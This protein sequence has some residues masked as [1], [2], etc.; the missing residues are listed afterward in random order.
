MGFDSEEGGTDGG[1][2]GGMGGTDGTDGVGVTGDDVVGDM[3]GVGT[4]GAEGAGSGGI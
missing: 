2:T 3:V 4:V 1:D